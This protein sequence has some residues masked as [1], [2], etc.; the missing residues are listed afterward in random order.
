M[1]EMMR[2]R[3]DRR[4]ALQYILHFDGIQAAGRIAD[5]LASRKG[6]LSQVLAELPELYV[7]NLV[8]PCQWGEKGRVLR[9]LV[10]QHSSEQLELQEGVKIRNDKGW[11]LVLPD[12]EKPQF[13]IYAEGHSEEFAQELA[14][15]FTR[16]VSSLLGKNIKGKD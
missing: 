10:D 14:A 4:V 16:K 15:E 6:K 5:F 3:K 7:K 11:T 2:R 9:E 12:S 1:A 13:N 8:I